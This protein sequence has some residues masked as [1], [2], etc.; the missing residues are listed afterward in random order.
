MKTL[1]TLFALA[2]L[3][4]TAS[5]QTIK[6]LG[7]DTASGEVVANT[8]TN[9]LTFTNGLGFSTNAAAATRENL[10]VPETIFKV[11]TSTTLYDTNELVADPDLFFVAEAN[12]NYAVTLFIFTPDSPNSSNDFDAK[13]TQTGDA[14]IVGTWTRSVAQDGFRPTDASVT[15]QSQIFLTD[16]NKVGWAQYFTVFGGNTNSTITLNIEPD[17]ECRIGAGSYLKAEAIE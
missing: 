12:K 10:G 6:A 5:A 1:T 3:T 11:K 9:V 17:G 14:D 4:A 8:G 13:I 7:Y 2:I 15:D 16:D